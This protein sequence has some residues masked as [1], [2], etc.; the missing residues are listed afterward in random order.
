MSQTTPKKN[1]ALFSLAI[2]LLL[3]AGIFMYL[4]THNF[5]IRSLGL[6]ALVAS[7]YFVR[8]SRVH[9]RSNFSLAT[10]Q[11][12]DVKCETGLRRRL[13]ILSISMVPLL[14]VALL[15]MCS[16]TVT[17]GGNKTWPVDVFAGVALVCAGVWGC[18]VAVITGSK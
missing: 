14:V 17:D 10:T 9:E 16:G 1:Y 5:Q 4:G 6:A 7:G 11:P 18:L 2:L 13:W 12:T 15:L 8:V 3:V